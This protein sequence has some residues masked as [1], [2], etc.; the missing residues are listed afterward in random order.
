MKLP[1]SWKAVV[2]DE[3]KKPYF[4][5]LAE[6]LEAERAQHQV[7]PPEHQV[8]T[9]L[10]LTEYERVRVMILGQDPYHDDGQAHGLAF[11]VLPGVRFPASLRNIFKEL[12]DDV[13][14]AKPKHGCL[15]SWAEQDVLLLN[16]VL[17]VRAH[18][19]NSHRGKGWEH[20]TD[21]IIHR[22]GERDD[23]MIFVLWGAHA[24]AKI[25]IIDVDKHVI[26]RSA[27]PSPLSAKNGFFGSTPFSQIN[28]TLRKWGKHEIDWAI[29]DEVEVP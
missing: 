13:G 7:F 1:A 24:Q 11:S 4:Q 3:L 10:K 27:H 17:T 9:A 21:A 22:L 23:P 16:T 29:P 19:P 18:E 12:H 6:F 14:I 15:V 26:L 25:K 5:K 20:F 28:A 8:F 2:G